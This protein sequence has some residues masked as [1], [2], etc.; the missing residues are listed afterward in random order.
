[1]LTV[2]D[3]TKP[4]KKEDNRFTVYITMNYKDNLVQVLL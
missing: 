3:K 2:F 4:N 1:M